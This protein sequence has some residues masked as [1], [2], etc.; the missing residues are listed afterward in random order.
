MAFMN[1]LRKPRGSNGS[2]GVRAKRKKK[3]RL[4]RSKDGTGTLLVTRR[5]AEVQ[6]S[7]GPR[8]H[9]D[10]GFDRRS[11]TSGANISLATKKGRVS[12]GVS[13]GPSKR[14]K[15]RKRR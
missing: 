1:A 3:E 2:F 12:R 14:R 7:I 10:A 11:R 9:V 8:I 4:F 15:K 6:K 13:F 5:G